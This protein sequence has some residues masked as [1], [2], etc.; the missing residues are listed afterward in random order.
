[1]PHPFAYNCRPDYA[2]KYSLSSGVLQRNSADQIFGTGVRRGAGGGSK[3]PGKDS[4]PQSGDAM[5][6]KQLPVG[7]LAAEQPEAEVEWKAGGFASLKRSKSAAPPRPEHPS[8]KEAA[9]CYPKLQRNQR[10]KSQFL[11]MASR[12]SESVFTH[13]TS[14]ENDRL[15][16]GKWHLGV[17]A[18]GIERATAAA[19]E[20]LDEERLKR[21]AMKG[22]QDKA[23]ERMRLE[24]VSRA[25]QQAVLEEM[26]G[27][28]I[29][30]VKPTPDQQEQTEDESQQPREDSVLAE[31][32]QPPLD[33][34]DA[35][36][37]MDMPS[38]VSPVQA[39]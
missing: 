38:A 7:L 31:Q 11:P 14:D 3:G 30:Q 18:T 27:V 13:S 36:A 19:L 10:H 2:G 15:R 17:L 33:G 34:I 39:A 21:E 20:P 4:R 24:G 28:L 6:E 9:K 12:R 37:A 32:E 25:Q 23:K 26:R 1:M 16:C 5:K 29:E 22:L 8:V 35:L